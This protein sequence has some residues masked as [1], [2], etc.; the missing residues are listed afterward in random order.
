VAPGK[1]EVMEMPDTFNNT[2]GAGTIR[3]DIGQ[4][5]LQTSRKTATL[6]LMN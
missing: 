5:N 3:H 4:A 6:G 1:W 2:A